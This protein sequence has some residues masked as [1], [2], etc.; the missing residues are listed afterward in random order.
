MKRD[1]EQNNTMNWKHYQIQVI[2]ICYMFIYLN[3]SNRRSQI[4]VHWIAYFSVSCQSRNLY[5]LWLVCYFTREPFPVH[6]RSLILL[7]NWNSCSICYLIEY[8]YIILS[9]KNMQWFQTL[10]FYSLRKSALHWKKK[11]LFGNISYN[12]LLHNQLCSC[13]RTCV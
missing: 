3:L 9:P 6:L 8:A 2:N 13:T 12:K 5:F 10:K 4:K 1:F 7:Q 11:S